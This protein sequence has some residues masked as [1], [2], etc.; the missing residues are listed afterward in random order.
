MVCRR[1]RDDARVVCESERYG[2]SLIEDSHISYD[3][4]RG[5]YNYEGRTTADIRDKAVFSQLSFDGTSGKLTNI[6]VPTGRYAGDTITMWLY[7]LHLADIWGMPYRLFVSVM[8]LVVAMLSV[9]G[10]VIWW[11]KFSARRLRGASS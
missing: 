6:F 9:T 2:F 3:A 5:L 4:A 10:V 1:G 7:A 8:G 11:K